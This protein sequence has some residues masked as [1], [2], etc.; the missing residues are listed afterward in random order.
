M[1]LGCCLPVCSPRPKSRRGGLRPLGLNVL[2]VKLSRRVHVHRAER[3]DYQP[4]LGSF[5]NINIIPWD[6]WMINIVSGEISIKFRFRSRP[7]TQSKHPGRPQKAPR[8]IAGC[9]YCFHRSYGKL[10]A[11][12]FILFIIHATLT[13]A[14]GVTYAMPPYNPHRF[15]GLSTERPN[16]PTALAP[17]R[18]RS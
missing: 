1:I 3:Q 6:A 4:S 7:T 14:C 2:E 5:R 10:T 15:N 16:S 11:F 17:P 8:S 13:V 9:Y 12:L 18:L